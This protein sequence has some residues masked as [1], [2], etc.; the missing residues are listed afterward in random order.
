MNNPKITYKFAQWL[1]SERY[2]NRKYY[3]N[4]IIRLADTFCRL[5][6]F[7]KDSSCI[8]Q[9][10]KRV[11]EIAD[12]CEVS[13]RTLYTRLDQ[14]Q[15]HG[16]IDRDAADMRM[17]SWHELHSR[18][19]LAYDKKFFEL[20]EKIKDEKRLYHWVYLA[21]IENN[22]QQ[23]SAA[24]VRKLN[25]NHET[26]NKLMNELQRRGRDVEYC[27]RNTAYLLDCLSDLYKDGFKFGSEIQFILN[28]IRPFTDRSCRGLGK[29]WH[30]DLPHVIDRKEQ[31]R[32]SMLASYVKKCMQQQQIGHVHKNTTIESLERTRNINCW[33][34]WNRWNKSTFHAFCDTVQARQPQPKKAAAA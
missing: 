15:Q 17:I 11:K 29:A 27:S 5:K 18:L 7:T 9:W 16:W 28:D 4:G 22:R 25:K 10:R 20:P 31:I 33:V 26:K 1:V 2:Q 12:V 21:E 6:A 8:K 3:T 24:I 32:V 14:L 13:S 34:M 19:G 23:Q 30:M